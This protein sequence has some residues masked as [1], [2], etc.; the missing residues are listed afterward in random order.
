MKKNK[1]LF[2]FFDIANVKNFKAKLKSVI[3]PLLTSTTQ[4]LDNST[5]PVTALNI[6]FSQTGLTALG[7]TD[8]LNDF[9]FTQGQF[10]NAANLSDPGTGNWVPQFKG[11]NIHGVILLASDTVDNLNA[12]LAGLQS[13]LGNSIQEIYSLQ[14]AARPGAEQ[15][16]E[17]ECF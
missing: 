6:A 16:H 17:R 11:T 4:L 1:E 15:G 8:D 5:Q 9:L 12:T 3:L 10:A 14:A 13:A 2:F 7:I